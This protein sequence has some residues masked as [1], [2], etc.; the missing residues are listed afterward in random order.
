MKP[1]LYLNNMPDNLY[2]KRRLVGKILQGRITKNHQLIELFGDMK[3]TLARQ[4]SYIVIDYVEKTL[5][6]LDSCVG[7]DVMLQNIEMYWPSSILEYIKNYD[8]TLDDDRNILKEK[9]AFFYDK[10]LN[11]YY[12][13]R[14]NIEA[15]GKYYDNSKYYLGIDG[16]AHEL[17]TKEFFFKDGS[18][19]NLKFIFRG[20]K[21]VDT[22]LYLTKDKDIVAAMAEHRIKR[23]ELYININILRFYGIPLNTV[24]SPVYCVDTLLE[25]SVFKALGE[26]IELSY[27]GI[28]EDYYR[29]MM[30]MNPANIKTD[31]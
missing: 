7:S 2:V 3:E 22:I 20:F 29:L 18:K 23:E 14:L 12:N 9:K 5:V 31:Y 25:Q 30:L 10:E 21:N 28:E 13:K 16:E 8:N 27:K 1:E 11:T 4:N 24:K 26:L 15:K 19:K 6:R 17:G